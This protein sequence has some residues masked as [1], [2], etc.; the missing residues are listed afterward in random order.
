MGA[1]KQVLEV[2]A[3]IGVCSPILSSPSS[4]HSLM[5]DAMDTGSCVPGSDVIGWGLCVTSLGKM[6]KS[7][8][9]FLHLRVIKWVTGKL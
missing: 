4:Q 3:S 7:Y 8:N 5:A 6:C 1:K 9:A 2:A